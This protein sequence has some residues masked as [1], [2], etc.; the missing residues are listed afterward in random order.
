[1]TDCDA[2]RHE[3]SNSSNSC[4]G[5]TSSTSS[6]PIHPASGEKNSKLNTKKKSILPNEIIALTLSSFIFKI[7]VSNPCES[8][9]RGNYY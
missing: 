6:A 8:N 5:M 4:I 3:S 2:L 1:M 7:K 9:R